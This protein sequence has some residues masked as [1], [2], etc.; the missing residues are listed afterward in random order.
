MAWENGRVVE[1]P[2]DV[3]ESYQELGRYSSN[4]LSS[5]LLD[6]YMEIY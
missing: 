4:N 3:K 1:K 5:E 2:F 6:M